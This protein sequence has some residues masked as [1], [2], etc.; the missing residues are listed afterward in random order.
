M[1]LECQV[2][3][4]FQECRGFQ[5]ARSRGKVIEMVMAK[6]NLYSRYEVASIRLM[7]LPQGRALILSQNPV[8]DLGFAIATMSW[9][10]FDP[11][12]RIQ[13]DLIFPVW[14][15]YRNEHRSAPCARHTIQI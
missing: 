4:G 12:V 6:T 5:R 15:R 3:G 9:S 2:I 11:L 8:H 1:E 14:L 7:P 10:D 13:D